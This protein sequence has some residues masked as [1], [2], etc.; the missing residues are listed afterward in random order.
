MGSRLILLA[1]IFVW[2]CEAC[3]CKGVPTA[4]EE[5]AGGAMVFI[6]TVESI[7]PQFLDFW[8]TTRR[9]LIRG[10]IDSESLVQQD[11]SQAAL[12]A[13]RGKIQDALP[14]L[15]APLARR[16]EAARTRADIVRA[17]D[18]VL[19]GGRVVRF[20]VNTIFATG[21][22]V[23]DDDD[24]DE[25]KEEEAIKT[26]ELTNR[27]DDCGYPFQQSEAYLVYAKRDDETTELE[28]SACSA[29]KRL[30]DAGGD[31]AYLYFYRMNRK[32]ASR[33]TGVTRYVP[34]YGSTAAETAGGVV[35]G[36]RSGKTARYTSSDG[37]GR[38][39]FDGLAPGEY[40]LNV[41]SPGYPDKVE[42]LAGPSTFEVFAHSCLDRTLA[43]PTR[44]KIP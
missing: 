40:S 10:I 8:N 42:L 28:T 17:F 23:E 43:I 32:A 13:L 2:A 39:T 26:V 41:W 25:E 16:L 36:I 30:S 37:L 22:E 34:L 24:G 12:A 14:D 6:G 3:D 19:D 44:P 5:A 4:C 1:S 29:T 15:P 35:V 31:L 27:F 7:T 38:F 21:A 18:R 9:Q 11:Q 20:R 33:L